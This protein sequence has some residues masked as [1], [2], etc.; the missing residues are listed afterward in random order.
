MEHNY[1][2]PIFLLEVFSVGG[3]RVQLA[4]L[5]WHPKWYVAPIT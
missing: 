4:L 1:K 2:N 3:E 5:G